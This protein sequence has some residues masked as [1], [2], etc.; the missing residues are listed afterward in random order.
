MTPIRTDEM[1]KAASHF[2]EANLDPLFSHSYSTTNTA[3]NLS[4]KTNLS[5]W[6]WIESGAGDS[7]LSRMSR[8][9]A[10]MK[11]TQKWEDRDSILTGSSFQPAFVM[12]AK[13]MPL[14]AIDWASLSYENLIND[15][16]VVDVGGG[17][18]HTAR[19]VQKAFPQLRFVVQDRVSVV[20]TAKKVFIWTDYEQNLC[21]HHSCGPTKII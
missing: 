18:G 7:K 16:V 11:A 8:T 3:F 14:Q 10:A 21:S 15:L 1:L 6:E 9:A 4:F 5:Y 12:D 20:E 2:V 13:Y 17:I 19:V